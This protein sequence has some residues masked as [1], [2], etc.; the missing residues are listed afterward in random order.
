MPGT[1]PREAIAVVLGE[2]PELPYLPELP[3]RGPGADLV[4]RTASLLVDLPVQTTPTG[5]RLTDAPG[6]DQRRAADLLSGDLDILAEAAAGFAG[7]FKIQACGPW[8]L[9]ASLELRRSVEPALAD[10]GAVADLAASLAEGLAAH[11]SEVRARLPLATVLLQLDEPG[12]PGVL[13]GSVPTASGLYRLPAVEEPDA[14][15]SLRGVRDAAGVPTVVHCCAPEIP[16]RCIKDA[17]AAA[18]SFDLGLFRRADE[19]AFGEAVESGVGMFIGA[20][21]AVPGAPGQRP[22]SDGR[23]AATAV[24]DRWLR[25]GLPA[26]SLTEQVVVTPACGLAGAPPSYAR[27]A[28]E[29]C[30]AAARLIPELIEE[31]VR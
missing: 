13:A 17:G 25:I 18:A 27:A 23:L 3:D 1:D 9:A 12:L 14:A 6:R 2:L 7:A 19:D 8:T 20:V 30:Q 15:D 11:V 22:D 31:G 16:F 26:G 5:W 4:G 24:I 28:L 10:P 29:R 21:P